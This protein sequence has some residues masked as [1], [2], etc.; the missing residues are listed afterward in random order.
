M[1]ALMT[2]VRWLQDIATTDDDVFVNMGLLVKQVSHL[3]L[4]GIILHQLP[5]AGGLRQYARLVS[6][7]EGVSAAHA[8]RAS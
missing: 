8:G 3:N 2:A 1:S 4:T 5:K 6:Y 7:A